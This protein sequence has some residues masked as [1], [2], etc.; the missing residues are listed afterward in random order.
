MT[1][2]K[3]KLQFSLNKDE[4]MDLGSMREFKELLL[5]VQKIEEQFTK[6]IERK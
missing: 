4:K 6:E 5:R 1:K 3:P 2:E